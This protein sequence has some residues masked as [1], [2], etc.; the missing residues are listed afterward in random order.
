MVVIK[1]MYVFNMRLLSLTE[2]NISITKLE[3]LKQ[4]NPSLFPCN[5]LT[6]LKMTEPFWCLC[7]CKCCN[8][9]GGHGT[10][11]VNENDG[12]HESNEL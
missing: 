12:I 11:G 9:F 6:S 1:R 5:E 4:A 8:R 7:V 3:Y 2:F 10:E